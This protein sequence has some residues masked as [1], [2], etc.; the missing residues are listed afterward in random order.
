MSLANSP[1]GMSLLWPHGTQDE[2]ARGK[3]DH[4]RGWEGDLSLGEV[5]KTLDI[6]G[7]HSGKIRSILLELCD[8]VAVI[9][10][11]QEVLEDFL[12]S[13]TLSSRLA[14]ILPM[15]AELGRFGAYGRW[16]QDPLLQTV[17]RLEELSLYV[18]AVVE[19]QEVFAQEGSNLASEGL[20]SLARHLAA[21]VG[22]EVFKSLAAE[23][24][25][26]RAGLEGLASRNRTQDQL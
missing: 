6:D 17:R 20:R 5:A 11:R 14:D 9:R 23:L 12:N 15:M 19:L 4:G 7:R 3:S 26:L 2:T 21:T 25:E 10:Y 16:E 13:P 18:D 8:D 24:P 22:E 1:E